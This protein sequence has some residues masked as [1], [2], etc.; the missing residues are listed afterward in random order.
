MGQLN[1]RPLLIDTNALTDRD[2]FE[3]LKKYHGVKKISSVAYMEYALFYCGKKKWD[4]DKVN[5][6]LKSADIEIEAFDKRQ[7]DDAI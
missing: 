2:F 3:W 1:N 7:A 4:L 6:T 5:S